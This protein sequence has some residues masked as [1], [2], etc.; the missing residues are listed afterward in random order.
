MDDSGM[1]WVAVA[2]SACLSL[3]KGNLNVLRVEFWQGFRSFGAKLALKLSRVAHF[4]I[5]E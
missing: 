4:A 5:K 2:L 3:K 1:R